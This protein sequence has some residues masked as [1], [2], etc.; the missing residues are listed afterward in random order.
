MRSLVSVLEAAVRR[1]ASEVVLESGRPVVYTS[2]RGAETESAVLARTELFDMISAAVDDA[3]QVELAIGN[4]VEFE[5]DAGGIWTV[6]AEPGMDGMMVRAHRHG[7]A[8]AL[9]IEGGFE[10]DD[11]ALELPAG[12]D[13]FEGAALEIG[14]DVAPASPSQPRAPSQLHVE[15]LDAPALHDGFGAFESAPAA[16]FESG[17]WTLE[18]DDVEREL[19]VP[20]DDDEDDSPF[21]EPV[22]PPMP[23]PSRPAVPDRGPAATTRREMAARLAHAATRRDLPSSAGPEA[24]TH[25]ELPSAGVEVGTHRE[26]PSAGPSRLAATE[27]FGEGVL[28]YVREPGLAEVV[29]ESFSSPTV[30]VD[31]EFTPAEAWARVRGLPPGTVVIVRC[32]E[33]PSAM[34][35]W[36]LRRLEEGYRVLLETRARTPEGAR[37]TLL[38]VG[39]SERAERWLDGLRALTLEP[40]DGGPTLREAG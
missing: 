14:F 35:G 19:G 20:D 11:E 26:L 1:S 6:H 38:G 17:T 37:R 7:V 27:L 22:G 2:A 32:R 5:L 10:F 40:G 3:Q 36:I 15:A 4:S 30:S 28:V 16:S 29:A 34:L 24:E 33:D 31:E 25:R 18:D 39:A 21:N 8:P 12:F 9:E 13:E 23:P